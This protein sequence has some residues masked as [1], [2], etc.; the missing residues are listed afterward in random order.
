MRAAEALPPPLPPHR[1]PV[2]WSQRWR[3][4]SSMPRRPTSSVDSRR[5]SPKNRKKRRT[6]RWIATQATTTCTCT[7]DPSPAASSSRAASTSTSMTTSMS[8]STTGTDP[9]ATRPT[10]ATRDTRDTTIITTTRMRTFQSSQPSTRSPSPKS[11]RP[12]IRPTSTLM[13]KVRIA[14]SQRSSL[15]LSTSRPRSVLSC[16]HKH[17]MHSSVV[18]NVTMPHRE[19]L[20]LRTQTQH[21]IPRHTVGT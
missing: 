11:W 8:M 12:R 19:R 9:R 7:R 4:W 5:T 13:P 1:H 6:P 14:A 18:S 20:P 16:F 17:G 10:E 15:R 2:T 3:R 21:I